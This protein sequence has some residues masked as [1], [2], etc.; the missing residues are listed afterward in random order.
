MTTNREPKI[1]F[2]CTDDELAAGLTSRLSECGLSSRILHAPPSPAQALTNGHGLIL[3]HVRNDAPDDLALLQ[4]L[5]ASSGPEIIALLE[6]ESPDTGATALAHGAVSWI[7]T[8]TP[9]ETLDRILRRGLDRH[10][11]RLE[12]EDARRRFDVLIDHAPLGVFEIQAGRV[13]SAHG[14]LLRSLGYSAEDV[15]GLSPTDLVVPEDRPLLRD[16]LEQRH[17]G[18]GV[19]VPTIYR[20]LGKDGT[21]HI[22]EVRS[23]PVGSGRDT[24]IEGIIRDV[25][26]EM[27]LM[28]L[29]RIVLELGEVILGDTDIDRI[30]QSVLDAITEHGGFRRAVLSLYDLTYPIPFEGPTHKLLASGLTPLEVELLKQQKPMPVAERRMVY[31]ERFKLGPAYY[32]PHNETPWSRDLGIAG[33]VST[34]S[35]HKDDYLFI[36]LRGI[37]GIIGSISVD[38]PVDRDVP[39]AA[40]ILPVASLANFAALAV[41]RVFKIRQ[42]Q[43]QKERLRGLSSFA[44][45]LAGINDVSALCKLAAQHVCDDLGHDYCGVWVIDGREIVLA[46]VSCTEGF[47]ED[48]VYQ[49]G[50]RLPMTGGGIT[51]RTLATGETIVVQDVDTD[52]RYKRT[53]EGVRSMVAV[54]IVGRKGVLAALDVESHR[55]ADFAEDDVEVLSALASELSVTISGLHWR[56]SL[57]RVYA[58]GQRVA[59]AISTQQ[60][61]AGTLDFLADHFDYEM[62]ALFLHQ[63]GKLSVA[64][65][66]G[67]YEAN[68]VHPG[69]TFPED[70]G[71]AAWVAR[72]KRYA[73]VNDAREDPRYF[74]GFPGTRSELAV[75]ILFSDRLL[76][77]LN[78]ESAQVGFFDDEDRQL[79]AVIANHIAIALSNLA[80]QQDLREQAI[81][82]PLTGLYNRHYFNS[83]IAPELSR[84]DRYIR[85][86]T[87]MMIDVDGF[88]AVNNRLGHLK[89]DEV[90]Q[91]VAK[92][93]SENV[94]AADRVIRYGGDEFLVF[95]PETVDEGVQVAERLRE[96]IGSIAA[97]TGI[98]GVSVG[99]SIG[100]YTRLPQDGRT[101]EEILEETDRRMYA[102]KRSRHAER[103]DDYLH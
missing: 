99:L 69:W 17:R 72:H 34:D 9:R 38:D 67:P 94:R 24:R 61:V 98:E 89:G 6:S 60:V 1:L 81:R 46:G 47:S 2:V 66:R 41:E 20:F 96:R 103:A 4:E 44:R 57:E 5:A 11:R 52:P 18:E 32:I 19:N 54:P 53:R 83:M 87:L 90:L 55:V 97:R 40:S 16:A 84:S 93:L 22:G 26:H 8:R 74:A 45:E 85:P 28:Q 7:T 21:T 79:L 73:L 48:E 58:F 36:P 78:I 25:T 33:N 80:S 86:I 68:H 10:Q 56:H 62:S 91:E 13:T 31:A 49:D 77:V 95:M 27:R 71:I 92:L 82:D 64:G 59:A 14:D 102:D 63:D 12:L 37:T 51:R 43:T 35:W 15:L 3:F 70:Q 100:I 75:P 39:T 42:L 30:L 50:L 101:L 76:G 29:H 23:R 88:R 65:I